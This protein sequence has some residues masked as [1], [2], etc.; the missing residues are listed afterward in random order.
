MGTLI[1]GILVL[2]VAALALRTLIR[3]KKNGKS[4]GGSCASCKG[5]GRVGK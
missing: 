3:D 4:C 5:C 1:V 2:G